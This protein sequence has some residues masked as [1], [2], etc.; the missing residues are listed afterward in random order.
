[1]GVWIACGIFFA[2]YVLGCVAIHAFGLG[3]ECKKIDRE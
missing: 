1:M 2:L 3:T